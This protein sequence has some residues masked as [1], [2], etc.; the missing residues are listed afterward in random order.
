[1]DDAGDWLKPL[2][3]GFGCLGVAACA[4]AATLPPALH[5]VV[6]VF[7]VWGSGFGVAYVQFVRWYFGARR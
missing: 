7:A 5:G 1:M 4:A 6:F 2:A 3:F